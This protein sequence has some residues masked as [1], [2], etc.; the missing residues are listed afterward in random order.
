MCTFTEVIAKLKPGYTA[1]WT[2]L[3]TAKIVAG[4]TSRCTAAVRVAKE[5]KE[6]FGDIDR[7]VGVTL[8]GN[9]FRRRNESRWLHFI[10]NMS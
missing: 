1:F 4:M 5:R 9:C 10:F 2:T 6:R 3:Y 7:R 8:T